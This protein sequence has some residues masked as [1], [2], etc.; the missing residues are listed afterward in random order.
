M[1]LCG[2][3][4]LHARVQVGCYLCDLCVWLHYISQLCYTGMQVVEYRVGHY[5][6]YVSK[7]LG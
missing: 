5:H 3:G 4:V 7:S 2:K 1:L 6:Q